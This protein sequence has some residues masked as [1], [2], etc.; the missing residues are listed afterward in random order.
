MPLPFG[1][2]IMDS[3]NKRLSIPRTVVV[4]GLVS[5]F[6]DV[7][8]EM[9]HALLPLFMAQT[10]GA[11]AL[12]IGFTEGAAE[13]IALISKVFSGAIA[14]RFGHRKLLVFLG[15][16][17]GVASKPFFAL[18]DHMYVA[19]LAR[20]SDRIGKGLRGA[21]RD[22]IVADVTPKEI[23]GAAFGLRQSLD[24]AGAFLG[25][26]IASALLFFWAL[27]FRTI[28]WIAL[29]PG[30]ICLCLVVFGVEDRAVE[31]HATA[32]ERARITLADIGRHLMAPEAGAFRHVV[33]LG[34]VFSLARF[35]NAFIVLRAADV[36]MAVAAVPLVMVGMNLVFSASCYPFGKLADHF[37]AEHLLACGLG[38]LIA[39]DIAFAAIPTQAGVI[40]GV[41]LWG[42]HLGATQG[43][44]SLMVA[45][46]ARQEVRATAY[47]VFN[48]CSGIAMLA[49]GCV[50]GL[51]WDLFGSTASFLG[52]AVFAMASV[53]LLLLWNRRQKQIQAKE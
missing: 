30:V 1:A 25:P 21:P 38:F 50:A 23:Q 10:L 17:L 52:G 16:G 5:L 4:L 8:S 27:D 19:M 47:G 51:L 2:F 36:G 15:Y 35:S 49:S 7:S 13:G 46:T 45:R 20:F 34:V 33:L 48:F 44:F 31:N 26:A 37:E 18:A 22:A 24:A 12:L 3:A 43:V 32:K 14:D 28:F 29:I 39:S 40:L 11:G 9:I 6:M 53:V 42:L 41:V